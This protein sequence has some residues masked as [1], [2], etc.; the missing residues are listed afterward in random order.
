MFL[1]KNHKDFIDFTIGL[2]DHDELFAHGFP[3][4]FPCLATIKSQDGHDCSLGFIYYED[5]A[6]LV[7]EHL[8]Q[9]LK[10]AQERNYAR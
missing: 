4:K 8:N 1:L 6:P 10:K 2:M 9:E 3:Q 5:I 7:M